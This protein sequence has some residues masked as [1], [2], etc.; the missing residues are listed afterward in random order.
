MVTHSNGRG[1]NLMTSNIT[2][3]IITL[4]IMTFYTIGTGH[5]AYMVWYKFNEFQAKLLLRNKHKNNLFANIANVWVKHWSYKWIMRIISLI[6][7]FLGIVG[8][9]GISYELLIG[10]LG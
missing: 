7:A 5:L 4:T 1:N 3:I 9:I 6:L 2:K 10:I 8:L